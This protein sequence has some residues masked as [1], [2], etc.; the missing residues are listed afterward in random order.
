MLSVTA[1][2]QAEIGLPF[3]RYRRAMIETIAPVLMMIATISR[4]QELGESQNEVNLSME[5]RF[6]VSRSK[7]LCSYAVDDDDIVE[8]TEECLA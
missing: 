6:V 2:F 8:E 4:F 5:L 7:R 3:S 1:S